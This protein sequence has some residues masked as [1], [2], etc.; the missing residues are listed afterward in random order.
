MTCVCSLAGTA[1][2]A[3]CFYNPNGI[4]Q[5]NNFM[6]WNTRAESLPTRVYI[7]KY[8]NGENYE[9][10]AVFIMGVYTS[11]DKALDAIKES[12]FEYRRLYGDCYGW[13]R[14]GGDGFQSA[15]IEDY[16]VQ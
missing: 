3:S 14:P 9:D 7:V 10:Y 2:C 12:G 1:A 11:E 4:K 13:E 6:T 15:W 5:S 16:E 8:D